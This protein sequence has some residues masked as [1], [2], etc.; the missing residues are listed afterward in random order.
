MPT[1]LS[2]TNHVMEKIGLAGAIEGKMGER[3][4]F[5]LEFVCLKLVETLGVSTCF[6][7]TCLPQPLTIASMSVSLLAPHVACAGRWIG[8]AAVGAV[9]GTSALLALGTL[10]PHI[11]AGL[12]RWVL[13]GMW[14]SRRNF[15]C[16]PTGMTAFS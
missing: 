10:T 15:I 16:L 8:D 4:S 13:P 5:S 9:A 14:P 7:P 3:S 11:V 2:I 12:G 6:L 1:A